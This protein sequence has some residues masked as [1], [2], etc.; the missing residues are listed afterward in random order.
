MD[1][2]MDNLFVTGL[3]QWHVALVKK[4]FSQE[5]TDL[6]L[7]ILLSFRS[8]LDRRIWHFEWSGKFIVQSAYH[9]AKS[10]VS[11]TRAGASGSNS[12]PDDG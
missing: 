8:T 11:S 1:S 12:K 10:L 3:P 2:I 7:S 4:L 6:I 9:V 5:E